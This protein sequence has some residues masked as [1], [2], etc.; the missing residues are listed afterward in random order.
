VALQV[1]NPLAGHRRK[2]CLNYCVELTV[3]ISQIGEVVAARSKMHLD[4]LIPMSAVNRPPV[5]SVRFIAYADPRHAN[6]GVC[7][8]SRVIL[9][10]RST[11][12]VASHPSGGRISTVGGIGETPVRVA[13][14]WDLRREITNPRMSAVPPT[15]MPRATRAAMITVSMN[16]AMRYSIDTALA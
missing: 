16:T 6:R 15:M 7:R 1:Q 9:A 5:Q 8:V 2:F 13:V 14:G 12:H 10:S 3:P 4:K 11:R